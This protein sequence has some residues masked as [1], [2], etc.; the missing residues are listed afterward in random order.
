MNCI[1]LGDKY[2]QGMKSKGCAGLININKK[3]NILSN[4]Y[5]TL[6]LLFKHINIV[7]IYGFDNKKF[8]DFVNSSSMDIQTKFNS[9]YNVYNHAFSLSLAKDLL[10]D[11]N[12]LIIDGYQKLNKNIFKKFDENNG[13]QIFVKASNEQNNESIGC[14]I[15]KNNNIEHFSFDLNNSIYDIY[16]LDKKYVSSLFKILSQTRYYNNFMFE[17]LNKLIDQGLKI[18]VIT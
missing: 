8:M 6:K 12:L 9:Q 16:Y 1:I 14:I 4:Q 13:S 3:T 11:D 2:Q 17:L 5:Q 15:N 10:E 7:Y 18:K